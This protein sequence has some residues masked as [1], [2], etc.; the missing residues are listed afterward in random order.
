[1]PIYKKSGFFIKSSNFTCSPSMNY[2]PS[3]AT[4]KAPHMRRLVPLIFILTITLPAFVRAQ[5]VATNPVGFNTV[6]V[7]INTTRA[8]ALPFN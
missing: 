4:V 5:T 6:T 3:L 2:L 7:N 8:L 1:M